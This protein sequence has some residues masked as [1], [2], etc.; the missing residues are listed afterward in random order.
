MAPR[1]NGAAVIAIGTSAVVTRKARAEAD[2]GRRQN[3]AAP[4]A[5]SSTVKATA[6]RL[7]ANAA[8]SG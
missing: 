2:S 6:G 3:V 4:A 1:P 5:S 8:V 7:S